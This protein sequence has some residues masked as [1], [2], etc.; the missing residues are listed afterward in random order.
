ML[1]NQNLYYKLNLLVQCYISK[2]KEQMDKKIPIKLSK[3]ELISKA[4]NYHLEGNIDQ[5]SRYYEIFIDTGYS[6]SR[7][8]SNYGVILKQKGNIKDA[9][10]LFHESIRLNA[11][12]PDPYSNLGVIYTNLGELKKAELFTLKA[13]ELKPDLVNSYINMTTILKRLGKGKDSEKYALEALKINNRLPETHNNLGQVLEDQKRHLVA[14]ECYLK[15]IE[16]K[17]EFIEAYI[18][19]G[20]LLVKIGDLKEAK[21]IMTK[22]LSLCKNDIRIYLNLSY[23]LREMS[24][25]YEA[26]SMIEKAINIKPNNSILYINLSSI[27]RDMGDLIGSELAINKSIKL[28]PDNEQ[29]FY[30]LSTILIDLG[31]FKEAELAARKTIQINR[32]F[33]KAYYILSTLIKRINIDDLEKSLFSNE[34][35][36]NLRNDELIDLYFARANFLHDKKEYLESSKYLKLANNIKIK[37]YPTDV[38]SYLLT[39]NQ[40][41][42]KIYNS[43]NYSNIQS[44]S[45]NL[46]IVGMLRSGSTLIESILSMNKEVFD[47]G[48]KNIF[49][50]SVKEWNLD[51]VN[52]DLNDIYQTKI[53]NLSNNPKITTNKWLYNYRFS[54]L[55]ANQMPKGKIIYC[56]RHP[57]DNILSIYRAHFAKGHRYSSTLIDCTN[58]YINHAFIMKKYCE[59]FPDKIFQVKY[60]NLVSNPIVEIKSLI[61][62]LDWT[63]DESYLA[64]HLNQRI[65]STASNVQVRS[66]IN[67]NSINSWKNYKMMLEP[68]I[69]LLRLKEEYKEIFD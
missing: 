42:K 60:E 28:D 23:I 50:D 4:F 2:I 13:I 9:I 19:L 47:L 14:K 15:A 69:K 27:L 24:Q 16:I 67:T 62:W 54:G 53:N 36:K 18:N 29:S 31:K 52:N 43:K 11:K 64:S 37:L 26:K 59:I 41:S 55:I 8:M 32:Q 7:V 68:A 57:L 25:L 61:N 58:L 48:E 6:D 40:I 49:E 51:Q 33:I 56:S 3:E 22:A 35:S 17:P 21:E 30:N 65:V 66:K 45:E 34:I 46:F 39:P 10:N 12:N 5:A 1:L 20:N 44:Y 63:W 38:N